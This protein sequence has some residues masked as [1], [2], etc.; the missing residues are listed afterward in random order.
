MTDVFRIY[1][2]K[3][4]QKDAGGES[5][6]DRPAL[7]ENY[8]DRFPTLNAMDEGGRLLSGQ[9]RMNFETQCSQITPLR[10]RDLLGRRCMACVSAATLLIQPVVRSPASSH[11]YLS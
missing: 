4:G 6:A 10:Y 3:R 9:F 2:L 11:D 1:V 5:G 7:D 8:K